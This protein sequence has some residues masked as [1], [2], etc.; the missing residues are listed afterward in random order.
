[1]TSENTSKQLRKKDIDQALDVC[2]SALGKH[3][4]ESTIIAVYP[5][6]LGRLPVY[7]I[8]PRSPR[9]MFSDAAGKH[10]FL[11]FSNLKYLAAPGITL[12]IL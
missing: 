10:R 11:K 2:A 9:V 12:I 7:G 5:E 8:E 1:M 6:G 3:A 4:D